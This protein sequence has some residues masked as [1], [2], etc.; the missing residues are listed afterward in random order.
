MF[1]DLFWFA[2]FAF[3]FIAYFFVMALIIVDLFRDHKLNGWLKAVWIVFL[4]IL[5]FLTALVYVIARGNGMAERARAG[6]GAVPEVDDYRPKASTSPAE[7]IAQ[8]K[9][10]L[11]SGAISQGEFDALK[12]KALGN[13]YFGA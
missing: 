5:P 13:Q 9:A 11:D 8:A 2:L 1:L 4:I 10:L 6:R 12:S 3:Y 7:D